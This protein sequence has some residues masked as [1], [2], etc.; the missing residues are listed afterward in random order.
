MGILL[1]I[2][3][4]LLVLG[5]FILVGYLAKKNKGKFKESDS[6]VSNRDLPTKE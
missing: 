1:I 3:I 4:V 6:N 2:L 5:G